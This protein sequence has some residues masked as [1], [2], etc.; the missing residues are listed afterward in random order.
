MP[1]LACIRTERPGAST[2]SLAAA[3]SFSATTIAIDGCIDL[4]QQHDEFVATGACDDVVVAQ[5]VGQA[6]RHALQQRYR[7]RNVRTG[8]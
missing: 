7:R 2:F 6:Q 1:T 4:R 5:N 3:I 8:R